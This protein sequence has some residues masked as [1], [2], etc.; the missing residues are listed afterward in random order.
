M[1]AHQTEPLCG[2]VGALPSLAIRLSTLGSTATVMW[3]EDCLDDDF[4]GEE[5]DGYVRYRCPS[6]AEH[7]ILSSD[8]SRR[9][10][11]G[12][13]YTSKPIHYLS[14]GIAAKL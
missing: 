12:L 4:P 2:E 11:N 5:G 6:C 13:Q 1:T 14:I 9:V 10:A 8:G 3:L 7:L